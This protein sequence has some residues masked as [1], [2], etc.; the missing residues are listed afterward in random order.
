MAVGGPRAILPAIAKPCKLFCREL[1]V[2]RSTSYIYVG[3]LSNTQAAFYNTAGFEVALHMNTGC[4]DWTPSSLKTF[5]KDQLS[6]FLAQYTSLPSPSTNRTHCIAWSDYATQPQVELGSRNPPGHEVI[7]YPSTWSS[8]LTDPGSLPVPVCR[9]ASPIRWDTHRCVSG[10]H[11][12][13]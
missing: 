6:G 7:I 9:C 2:S 12:D 3:S 10:C 1:G 4:A 11:A 13:D 8:T 5:Y